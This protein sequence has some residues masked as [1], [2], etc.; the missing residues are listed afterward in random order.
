[1]SEYED[2]HKG[3]YIRVYP[4]ADDPQNYTTLLDAAQKSWNEYV[5]IKNPAKLNQAKPA[6]PSERK[7]V[8]NKK[9]CT[10]ASPPKG[11]PTKYIKNQQSTIASNSFVSG[12]DSR[13]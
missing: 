13:R 5:G 9:F 1:M 6:K 11:S 3:A 10:S 7:E 2:S 4:A 12:S 8:S